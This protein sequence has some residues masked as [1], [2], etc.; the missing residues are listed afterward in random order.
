MR[1]D[2]KSEGVR[3]IK[4][5]ATLV[6]CIAGLNIRAPGASRRKVF[7]LALLSSS[8]LLAGCATQ[9]EERS[10][11]NSN[12][13]SAVT[14]GL[15][16]LSKMGAHSSASQL[17]Q[18]PLRT[19]RSVS[20]VRTNTRGDITLNMADVPLRQAADAILKDTLGVPYSIDEQSDGRV[21]IQSS[22]PID[23]NAL[24]DAFRQALD[25][26]GFS[27]TQS[28]GDY[29]ITK[30][31]GGALSATLVDHGV[32]V[33]PLASIHVRDMAHILEP[34]ESPSL[35][36]HI[37]DKHNVLF[38][39]GDR[40][41][42]A[43]ALESVNL[44]DVDVMQ[45][46]SISRVELQTANPTAIATELSTIFKSQRNDGE[47]LE[48]IPNEVLGSILIVASNPR[49]ISEAEDWIQKLEGAV[50]TE[51]YDL[52][53]RT[54][55]DLAPVLTALL[56]S[57][58]DNGGIKGKIVADDTANAIIA[59]ASAGGH[60]EIAKLIERLDNVADQVLIEATIAEVELNDDLKFGIRHFFDYGNSSNAFTAL[61]T[62]GV[63]PVFPGFSAIFEDGN[64]S[65]ALDALST[66][67]EV[68]I[69]SSPSLLVLDNRE[70][71]L[72]VGDQVPVVTQSV[73]STN[74][75][76]APIVNAVDY[77]DTGVILTIK[78]RVDASGRV[79]L[80]IEQEVS[81]VV[82]TATSGIDSPTIQQRRVSTTVAMD[83][84]QSLMLGGLIRERQN[85]VRN[86]IPVLGDAP[87]VGP[88]FRQVEDTSKRTELLIIITPKVV[89]D[90]V[91]AWEVTNEYRRKL[92]TPSSL[93]NAHPKNTRHNFER[94]FL[95]HG[96]VVRYQDD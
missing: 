88:L 54:A 32:Y 87:I 11:Q 90:S 1:P 6:M 65:F 64:F 73:V 53:N 23:K 72:N 8:A 14:P 92:S 4:H 47:T 67:T 17:D 49:Y 94:I 46:K 40:R 48:F 59:H 37:D 91:E 77:R 93:L 74:D 7:L 22:A 57:E 15:Q 75:A 25:L 33:V 35:K 26:N 80:D 30:K 3:S 34:L 96:E 19:M 12:G 36:A 85:R 86:Q 76:D 60:E 39:V 41:Q 62:A 24:L 61:T 27:L 66:I 52:R 63:A 82:E 89:R 56:A 84:G 16:H 83:N 29:S 70:A 5:G 68:N 9:V 21:T 81:D 51:V 50:R 31:P 20:P 45:G 44:F 43:A 55:A 42:V 71:V 28:N 79:I 78:P 58:N 18:K 38:L 10:L 13:T 69:V 2:N 95:P